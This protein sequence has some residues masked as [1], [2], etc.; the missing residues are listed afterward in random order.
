[1]TSTGSFSKKR[2]SSLVMDTVQSPQRKSSNSCYLRCPTTRRCSI[3]WSTMHNQVATH[4]PISLSLLALTI[5]VVQLWFYDSS[6]GFSCSTL[7]PHLCAR[8]LKFVIIVFLVRVS[9]H[10]RMSH[11]FKHVLLPV[12]TSPSILSFVSK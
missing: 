6:S 2:D 1:M 4:C 10:K 11:L 12:L 3:F 7:P 8:N 9:T 5:V